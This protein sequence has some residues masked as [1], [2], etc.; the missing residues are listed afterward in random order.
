MYMYRYVYVY[1]VNI[2]VTLCNTKRLGGTF[3]KWNLTA[4]LTGDNDLLANGSL[5]N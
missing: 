5:F 2:S 1:N 3:I 4:S